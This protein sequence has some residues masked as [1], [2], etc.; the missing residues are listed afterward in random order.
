M[1][2]DTLTL[3]ARGPAIVERTHDCDDMTVIESREVE[4][5]ATFDIDH[6]QLGD[7]GGLTKTGVLFQESDI[8]GRVV[9]TLS[10]DECNYV[11]GHEHHDDW[12]LRL[13]GRVGTYL[14]VAVPAAQSVISVGTDDKV[15]NTACW[16]LED[17][18]KIAA[19]DRPLI[20]MLDLVGQYDPA[21]HDRETIL[22][23]LSTDVALDAAARRE[24]SNA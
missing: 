24:G 5:H 1:T 21:D 14:D 9:D 7:L 13:T 4:L 15:A 23:E 20:A 18:A 19:D 22:A 3:H 12:E 17:V 2:D 10:T 16:I 11:A 8:A 6:V